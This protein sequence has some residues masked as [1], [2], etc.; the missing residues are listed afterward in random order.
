[1]SFSVFGVEIFVYGIIIAV[2]ILAA[3]VTGLL[4]FKRVKYN[5]NI[6]YLILALTVPLG[7][8]LARAYYVAFSAHNF[9]TFRSVIAIREGGMAI[10]GAIIGGA[11]G[12][13]IAARIIKCGFYTLAD[14][15]VMCVILAQS[16][17][18]WGNFVNQEAY[19]IATSNH[20]PPFTVLIGGQAHLATFFLE[21]ILNLV[22]F[23][24][25][26]YLFLRW[27]RAGTYR[28]GTMSAFYLI[29]YGVVRA[30]IEP[31]R[32]DSLLIAGTNEIVFNRVSFVLSIA[33]IVLGVLLLLA[34]RFGKV[35]QENTKCLKQ[36]PQQQSQSTKET[37][38][39]T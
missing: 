14:I 38:T 35:S 26:I 3:F 23:A 19:G 4:L 37:A 24:I 9:D 13:F 36:Q 2:A 7:I 34:T 10:Y 12:L 1:M 21:S 27:T 22:G 33:L 25:M 6:A 11:F 29:W 16:I 5:E 31:F 28:W 20:V 32:T 30:I 39:D 17:G 8:I 15:V 18:R